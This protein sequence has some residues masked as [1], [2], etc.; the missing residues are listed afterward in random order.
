M[1][2]LSQQHT[3]IFNIINNCVINFNLLFYYV[4]V[5]VFII[6][7][8]TVLL[9]YNENKIYTKKIVWLTS[10]SAWQSCNIWTNSIQRFRRCM[11]PYYLP[12]EEG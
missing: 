1:R 2:L 4:Q 10:Y 3:V 8:L 9:Y 5:H 12:A 6:V 7:L 11:D